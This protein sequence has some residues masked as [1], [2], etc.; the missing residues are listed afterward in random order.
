M[1]PYPA[2]GNII[3]LRRT[4]DAASPDQA[5]LLRVAGDDRPAPPLADTPTRVGLAVLLFISVTVHAALFAF[6]RAEPDAMPSAGEDAITVEIIVGADS[7]AGTD[8]D[9]DQIGRA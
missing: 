5:T 4:G 7:A 3:P 2:L 6:F 9:L 8:D 1:T